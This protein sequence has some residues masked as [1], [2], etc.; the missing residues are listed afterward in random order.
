[1]AACQVHSLR[2]LLVE[3]ESMS[4]DVVRNLLGVKLDSTSPSSAA[5]ARSGGEGNR[6]SMKEAVAAAVARRDASTR[7]QEAELSSLRAQ[8]HDLI[9]EREGY[10]LP[11]LPLHCLP[12]PPA[13]PA[14]LFL[15]FSLV[16]PLL[17]PFFA[18]RTLPLLH[19]IELPFSPCVHAC[20]QDMAWASFR[21]LG[22]ITGTQGIVFASVGSRPWLRAENSLMQYVI[23][24][25]TLAASSRAAESSKRK[26]RPGLF[27]AKSG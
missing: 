26:L 1:M 20:P 17:M 5:A 8:L 2:S 22:T 16:L 21:A 10:P 27:H 12:A 11:P 18:P 3:A 4:H 7:T 14:P 24:M 25:R 23:R 15:S 6:G 9:H 13:P 19:A